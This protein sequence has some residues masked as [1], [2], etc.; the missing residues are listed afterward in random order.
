M[1]LSGMEKYLRQ[2]GRIQKKAQQAA[3]FFV[4]PYVGQSR[5]PAYAAENFSD[6]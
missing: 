5:H 2:R 1:P 4:F 3:P 6:A